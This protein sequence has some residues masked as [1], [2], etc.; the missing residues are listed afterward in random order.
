MPVAFLYKTVNTLDSTV[1]YRNKKYKDFGFFSAKF[2]DIL[3]Y[4]PARITA[5]I[6]GFLSFLAGGWIIDI[7]RTIKKYSSRH[8]SPNSGFTGSAF[9]GALG[10]R[11]GGINHYFEYLKK[12]PYIGEKKK[13]FDAGDIKKR[14]RLSICSSLFLSIIV[15][16]SY[17]L[18]FVF[19][20]TI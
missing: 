15:I 3:N 8:A 9:A 11:F 7:F 5:L 16:L 18:L 19:L 14:L 10:L 1:E 2:D 17:I 12:T 20:T 13:D 6:S 4:L